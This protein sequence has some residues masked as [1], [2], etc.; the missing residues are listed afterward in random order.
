MGSN[1]NR[2]ILANVV[3]VSVETKK[4]TSEDTS[5]CKVSLISRVQHMSLL[6]STP[7]TFCSLLE[8]RVKNGS[9]DPV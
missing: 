5:A 7:V 2:E 4:P 9:Q 3:L 6:L 8:L 1:Q